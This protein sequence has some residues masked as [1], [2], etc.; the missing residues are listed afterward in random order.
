MR[1]GGFRCFVLAAVCW[2]SVARADEPRLTDRG[3]LLVDGSVGGY[4]SNNARSPGLTRYNDR[5]VWVS[6]ALTYFVLDHIGLGGYVDF[7]AQQKRI[8]PQLTR[9]SFDLG[10]GLQT[11]LELPL[12]PRLG[13]LLR[14]SAGYTHRWVRAIEG[15]SFFS[16]GAEGRTQQQRTPLPGQGIPDTFHGFQGSV[17]VPLVFHVSDSVGL[18]LGPYLEWDVYAAKPRLDQLRVGA[19]S[20]IACSF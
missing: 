9:H 13:L 12:S 16:T 7:D 14:V 10:A 6:P 11:T 5:S 18:G 3:R 2:C 15:G 1:I 17:F 8:Y 20:W 4:A 19:S